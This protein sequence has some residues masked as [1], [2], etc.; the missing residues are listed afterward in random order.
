MGK[1]GGASKGMAFVIGGS[2]FLAIALFFVGMQYL[3]T[4]RLE[5]DV[6]S[7][8]MLFGIGGV[9]AVILSSVNDKSRRKKKK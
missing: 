7:L 6:A 8:V 2:L 4:R 5:Y 9:F 1:K 3:S